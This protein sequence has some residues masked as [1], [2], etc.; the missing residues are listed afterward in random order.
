MLGPL[1]ETVQ[2]NYSRD[3]PQAVGGQLKSTEWN[4]NIDLE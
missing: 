1:W 3:D 4:P 2:W